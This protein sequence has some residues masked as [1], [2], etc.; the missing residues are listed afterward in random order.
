MPAFAATIRCLKAAINRHNLITTFAGA[1]RLKETLAAMG[2]KC[3]GTLRQRAERLMAVKGKSFD[4]L[5]PS[6]YAK[7]AK[8]LVKRAC[9]LISMILHQLLLPCSNFYQ[10]HLLLLVQAAQTDEQ[11]LGSL[12]LIKS[13]ALLEFKIKRLCDML[14][15]VIDDTKDRLEKRQAQTYEELML[16]KEEAEVVGASFQKFYMPLR[17]G[18]QCLVY[19]TLIC[20]RTWDPMRAMMKMITSTTL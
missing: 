19:G 9:A 16:E 10:L 6:L 15:S 18:A 3:G 1:D 20:C 11:Q 2:L 5:D 4:Q 7:G 13:T 14:A 12:Q 17:L 8:P